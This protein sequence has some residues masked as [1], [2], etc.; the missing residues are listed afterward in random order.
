MNFAA[1][2]QGDSVKQLDTIPSKVV[3]P[4]EGTRLWSPFQLIKLMSISM[5]DTPP[6]QL[7]EV[8]PLVEDTT[9]TRMVRDIQGQCG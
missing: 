3:D 2:V 7:R 5:T 9:L 4:L 8:E 6:G 1:V